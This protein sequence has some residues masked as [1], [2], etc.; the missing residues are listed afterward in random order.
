MPSTVHRM[1]GCAETTF[2]WPALARKREV[3]SPRI[4]AIRIVAGP[5]MTGKTMQLLLVR[6][7]LPLRSEP[8]QGSDPD[9]SD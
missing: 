7:A 2:D 4:V 9:L 3:P 8:G 1:R 5:P 6:H